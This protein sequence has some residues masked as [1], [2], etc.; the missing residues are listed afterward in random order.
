MNLAHFARF[1]VPATLFFALAGCEDPTKDK[2]KATVE[3]S[4]PALTQAA[5]PAG[6]AAEALTLDASATA[7]EEVG[8]SPTAK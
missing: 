4:A 5:L 2:P 1:I 8:L 6:A 7:S 3:A